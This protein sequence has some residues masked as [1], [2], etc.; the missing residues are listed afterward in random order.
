MM[1]TTIQ[2]LDL[3]ALRKEM[4]RYMAEENYRGSIDAA[5]FHVLKLAYNQGVIDTQEGTMS[6]IESLVMKK[7][8]VT[9]IRCVERTVAVSPNINQVTWVMQYKVAGKWRDVPYLTE[10]EAANENAEYQEGLVT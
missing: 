4:A 10:Q 9:G 5:L 6:N 2:M 3:N 8:A 7:Q 1:E